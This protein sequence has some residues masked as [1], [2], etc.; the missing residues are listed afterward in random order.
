M[1]TASNWQL[2]KPINAV[3]FDCDGT[4]SAIEGIDELAK[5]NNVGA[6]VHALTEKAMG[7]TGINPDLYRQRLDLVKPSRQQVEK[8]GESYFTHLVPDVS[9]VIQSFQRLNKIIYI[10]TAGLS[11]AIIHL[12]ARLNIPRENIFSV[13]LEFDAQGNYVNFDHNSPLTKSH[14]KRDIVSQIKSTHDYVAHI[15]DGLNDFVAHDVSTRF[16]GYG[17]IF[18]RKNI[19]AECEFYIKSKSLS[20]LLPLLLTQQEK[21]D[22]IPADSQLYDKGMSAIQ[23]GLVKINPAMDK[24]K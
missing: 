7:K 8:L 14:G 21:M 4:L 9:D 15:G 16:V 17:G 12:A 3:I 11:P 22:L 10:I 13:D 20:A 1:L 19:A 6:A 24:Q 5:E 2:Q 18:F 23:N